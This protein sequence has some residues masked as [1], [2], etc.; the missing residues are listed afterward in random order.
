MN[1]GVFF[2]LGLAL[3]ALAGCG[4]V[5]GQQLADEREGSEAAAAGRVT[6]GSNFSVDPCRSCQ[7]DPEPSGYAVIGPNN[8]LE[9]GTTQGEAVPFIAAASGVPDRI[10]TSLILEDPAHC[11]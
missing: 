5:L 10:T 9:P 1:K 11:P 8:C 7:Y 2:K 3:L 4:A 6:F